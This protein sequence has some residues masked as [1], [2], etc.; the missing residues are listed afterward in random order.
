MGNETF[1]M[2]LILSILIWYVIP[3]AYMYFWNRS[4]HRKELKKS[5]AWK[6]HG[7]QWQEKW[8]EIV[9]SKTK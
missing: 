3:T 8:A 5:E 1:Q 6:T 9:K 7:G 4:A 2:E